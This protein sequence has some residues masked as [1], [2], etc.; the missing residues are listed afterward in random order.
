VSECRSAP[1]RR[2][3]ASETEQLGADGFSL[4]ELLVAIAVLGI[5]AG[6]AIPIMLQARMR[7]NESAAIASLYVIRS[8]QATYATTC[9][10]G[11]FAQSLNDLT[12]PP[13][14]SNQSFV[15]E[16][17]GGNGVIRSGYMAN[18][19]PDIGATVVTAAVDTC[20]NSSAPAMSSYFAERHPVSI[21]LSGQRSFA[22]STGGTIVFKDDGTPI[23]PGMAG[24]SPLR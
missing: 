19:L 20:N 9:G 5:I 1:R 3:E 2:L 11:G 10:R 17:L 22:V 12:L 14:G 23:V 16:P 21:G 6:I 15:S 18:L 13:V 4:I 8:A 24:A 7:A